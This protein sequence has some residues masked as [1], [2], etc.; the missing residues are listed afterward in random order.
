MAF[1][2][3]GLVVQGLDGVYAAWNQGMDLML[4]TPGAAEP[5]VIANHAGFAS[6][7]AGPTVVIAWEEHGGSIVV[8]PVQ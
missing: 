3:E 1:V 5:K 7:A 6:L 2:Y 4:K 8:Q